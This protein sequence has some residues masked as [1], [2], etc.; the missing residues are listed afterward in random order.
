MK[1]LLRKFS[2][3]DGAK[4]VFFFFVLFGSGLVFIVTPSLFP[5]A[6]IS[7][8][9]FFVFGPIIDAF[10]RKGYSRSAAI[11]ALFLLC[12]IGITVLTTWLTPR[13]SHEIE[14]MSKGGSKIWLDLGSR[15]RVHENHLSER[16]PIIRGKQFSEKLLAQTMAAVDKIWIAIPDMASSLMVCL[17]LVPFFT[18][19]LLKESHEIKRSLLSLVPNRYF[20]TAYGLI[21]QILDDMGG[22]VAA[23]IIEAFLV[24]AMVTVGCLIFKIPYAVLLGVCAGVT[25]PIPYLGPL[26]G[27]APGIFLAILEPSTQGNQL[28]LV[29]LVYLFANIVDTIVIFPLV[30]AKIVDLHPVLVIISVLLGSQFF[31]IIGMLVAVPITTIFKI[32]F[33]E[34]YTK[35]YY[36]KHS[37]SLR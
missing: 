37:S 2:S 25:N 31:G 11:I 23:R 15:L 8:L 24:G 5:S 1:M 35:L 13:I 14:S 27:A 36:K 34:L 18:F 17:L 4:I 9:L 6:M 7:I 26:I 20:E 30:V 10:E 21:S 22:Y 29:T 12:G 16:F 32:L 28:F 33:T 19:V 3:L